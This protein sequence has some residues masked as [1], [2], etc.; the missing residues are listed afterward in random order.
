[1]KKSDLK[2]RLEKELA[3]KEI[4]LPQTLSAGNIEKLLAEKGEEAVELPEERV[5]IRYTGR[6]IIS[7]AAALILIIGIGAIVGLNIDRQPATTQ[8]KPQVTTSHIQE[9]E[10]NNKEPHN[11][12]E[13]TT[14]GAVT[15][16][17]SGGK[18]ENEKPDSGDSQGEEQNGEQNNEPPTQESPNISDSGNKNEG[19]I[20]DTSKLPTHQLLPGGGYD[21]AED[22]LIE[23]FQEYYDYFESMKP[24]EDEDGSVGSLD[25]NTAPSIDSPQ[26]GGNDLYSDDKPDFIKTD[27][28]YIYVYS[29]KKVN[30]VS[31]KDPK[32][33]KVVSTVGKELN[34]EKK[35]KLKGI[36]LYKNYLVLSY[37]EDT[38]YGSSEMLIYDVSNKASPQLV[39]TYSQKSSKTVTSK[40]TD[41]R[42]IIIS[43]YRIDYSYT[44]GLSFEEA[45]NEIADVLR[46][47]YSVNGGEYTSVKAE[48][49]TMI[50]KGATGLHYIV[51][52]VIDLNNLNEEPK[53]DAFLC[54]Q[55]NIA[56][57]GKGL[58]LYY[59]E[60]YS[61][62]YMTGINGAYSQGT[63]I[64]KLDITNEGV[65]YRC[66]AVICGNVTE[67][68]F[69]DSGD[70]YI[71]VITNAVDGKTGQKWS[72]INIL[73]EN[74][75]TVSFADGL[76]SG[77]KITNTVFYGG[78]FYL[79][80]SSGEV[81]VLDASDCQKVKLKKILLTDVFVTIL[82][83][84]EDGYLF[85]ADHQ[86]GN[87]AVID[88]RNPEKAEILGVYKGEGGFFMPEKDV[89]SHLNDSY[90]SS[91]TAYTYSRS[92]I[93]YKIENGEIK[94]AAEYENESINYKKVFRRCIADENA[95]YV[96]N[97]KC[98]TVFTKDGSAKIG[99]VEF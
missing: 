93:I 65:K 20:I 58:Y 62:L 75:N 14:A 77:E 11:N 61:S 1:M 16:T 69:L 95:V 25:N 30:I 86:E 78:V 22:L 63:N 71:K 79:A 12:N 99:E 42:L 73:D 38:Y 70:G 33:I 97:E 24:G 18:T 64:Y 83:L 9:H 49:I 72:M 3:G 17:Q 37:Y 54:S 23:N 59:S 52:S 56:V 76:L 98:I 13:T 82:S 29:D 90:F 4:K 51:S 47:S 35:E 36:H 94:K 8:G 87:F 6:K 80:S 28:E 74:L 19:E 96:I 84:S 57:M 55:C 32:N 92:F 15:T 67:G 89:F 31:A 2:K 91:F 81:Y 50:N 27:G 43:D 46:P 48:N 66:G 85:A 88:I 39:Y 10:D 7:A 5:K 53:T 41:G 45:C 26:T 44:K 68:L 21:E 60:E 34:G 40:I